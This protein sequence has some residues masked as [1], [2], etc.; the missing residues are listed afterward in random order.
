MFLL[1]VQILHNMYMYLFRIKNLKAI[2]VG[3]VKI[4]DFWFSEMHFS[5]NEKTGDL[6]SSHNHPR[7]AEVY[8]YSLFF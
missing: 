2:F 3:Y 6:T 8:K 7:N 4:L 1:N 5:N